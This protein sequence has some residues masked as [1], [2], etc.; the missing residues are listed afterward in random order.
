[1]N[2]LWAYLVEVG[3]QREHS[4]ELQWG[5]AKIPIIARSTDEAKEHVRLALTQDERNLQ[6]RIEFCRELRNEWP[7][8]LMAQYLH[9]LSQAIV[10]TPAGDMKQTESG[11]LI[12][13]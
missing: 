5:R 4:S 6:V 8:E 11:V 13:A 2:K 12:P 3:V 7:I 10:K 1:M 9:I